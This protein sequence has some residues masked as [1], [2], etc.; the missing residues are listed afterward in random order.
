MNPQ[1]HKI[2]A[3][4]I[5][6]KSLNEATDRNKVKEIWN[7]CIEKSQSIEKLTNLTVISKKRLN[8]DLSF[9]NNLTALF[10]SIILLIVNFDFYLNL[11]QTPLSNFLII[12]ITAILGILFTSIAII[13]L[14]RLLTQI[15]PKIKLKTVGRATL[16]SLRKTNN[17]ISKNVKVKTETHDKNNV[18]INLINAT[19]YEQNVFSNC[20]MQIFSGIN[21]PRYLLAKPKLG[22]QRDFYVVPDIFKKNKDMAKIFEKELAKT[23]GGFSIVFAKNET[24]KNI[25]IKAKKVYNFR[26]K[27]TEIKTKNILN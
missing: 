7:T 20:I 11:K 15:T 3:H 23:M 14:L 16:N 13:Y 17:I 24:G 12:T 4:I 2:E 18:S 6:S 26:Y 27:N 19:T 21:Q 10:L 5:N 22:I 8:Y 1:Q 9:F 25:V